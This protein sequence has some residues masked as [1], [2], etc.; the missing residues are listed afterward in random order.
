[1]RYVELQK[2]FPWPLFTASQY[3]DKLQK[4]ARVIEPKWDRRCPV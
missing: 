2:D 4:L 1:M 3:Q